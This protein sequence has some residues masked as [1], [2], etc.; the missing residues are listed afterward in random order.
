MTIYDDIADDYDAVVDTERRAGGAEAF[1]SALMAAH[2]IRSAVDAACGTGLYALAL[3]GKGVGVVGADLSEAMVDKARARGE[4]LGLAV[5]WLAS[6]MQELARRVEGP[7]DA[8]L[9]MGNSLPHLLTDEDLTD[10]VAG[11]RAMLS[12]GGVAVVSV[13]NYAKILADADRIV[14]ISRAGEAEYVRF[15]DFLHGR[16]RFNIL[17]MQWTGGACCHELHSTELRPYGADELVAA[18]REGGFA[19]AQLL[20][21]NRL[22]PFEP[23]ASD[24][25][26]VMATMAG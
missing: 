23:K 15:Y 10:T 14:G 8:V 3:A 5:R 1:V 11:F 17:K 7:V 26:I 4:E 6:P 13:L 20:G 21:S 25:L 12:P 19:E 24:V 9:C 2:P 22:E 18:F 16:V